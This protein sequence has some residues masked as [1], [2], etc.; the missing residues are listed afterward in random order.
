MLKSTPLALQRIL[1]VALILCSVLMVPR[2][3]RGQNK[4]WSRW[5]FG[6]YAGLRFTPDSAVVLTDS[7]M[8]SIAASASVCDSVGR[9]QLYSNGARVWNGRHQLLRNGAS[10][11]GDSISSQG[12]V[13][14]PRPGRLGNYYLFTLDGWP[15]NAV[16]R[17]LRMAEIDLNAAAGQGEVLLTNQP[18]VPDSLLQRLGRRD[19]MEQAALLRSADGRSWWLVTHLLDTNTFLSIKIDGTA[20]GR[21]NVVLSN[22]GRVRTILPG[23]ANSQVDGAG[24]LAA[25]PDGRRLALNT[26]INGCE[27]FDFDATTGR[28]S[29]AINIGYGIYSYGVAFSP[30]GRLLYFSR[31]GPA[32]GT[33]CTF[34]AITEV[35]QVD[36]SLPAAAVAASATVVYNG[37]GAQVWGM[38]RAPN[39][40]I[41]LANLRTDVPGPPATTLDV[42]RQPN[43]RGVGCQ[44]TF[45]GL[46]LGVGRWVV[47][48]FPVVPSLLPAQRLLGVEATT[49]TTT[50]A[51]TGEQTACVGTTVT[52]RATG[53]TLG[54]A[55]DTLEWE[56]GDGQR[57]RTV[58]QQVSHTYNVAG[59]YT[60]LVRLRS[61]GQAQAQ[62]QLV[63]VIVPAPTV[64]LGPDLLLCYGQST[65]L[66]VGTPPTG[67]RIR[68][69]DNSAATTLSA[70][71]PGWYWAELTSASGCTRR[72]SLRLS[73][74]AQVPVQIS[75]S[76]ALCPDKPVVL[77]VGPQPATTRYL[78]QDGSTSATIS[79][80]LPGLYTLT[81]TTPAG[82]QGQ[83]S[84]LLAYDSR[85]CAV[86][87]FL[88]NVITPN[89]D[90][91]NEFFVLKGLNAADW[92]LT[93]YNRWGREIFRQAGY[94]NRWSAAGQPAGVYHY[95]L[96]NPATNQK[97]RGWVEVMHP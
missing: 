96:I 86:T 4:E 22:A 55:S 29:N 65:T 64:N 74:Q 83:S 82:C 97:I 42:I 16:R 58:Q 15:S 10:L 23:N 9:L 5:Y 25:S 59:R 21:S 35:R 56:F 28:V 80:A 27:V 37:C 57:L 36:V 47:R 85:E 72:D 52:L 8:Y 46:D 94:D 95:L 31:Q 91:A 40:L 26:L 45:G 84:L 43:V 11:G 33:A 63:L 87:D 7:R 19:F 20:F 30:N 75:A 90:P 24:C 69:Q 66:T 53:P 18:V 79:A 89:G 68:W 60:L 2:T 70:A 61:G 13:V 54:A 34:N 88:P 50:S 17:G 71:A 92:N 3:A 14:V 49:G 41:Y 32:A 38:Q 44:Y 73:W 67:T 78:W 93:I 12:C 76:G 39:G 62:R 81:L 77:G 51:T 6:N 1:L 48:N